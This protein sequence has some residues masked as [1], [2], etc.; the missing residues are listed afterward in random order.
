MNPCRGLRRV[1]GTW[2]FNFSDSY[3]PS[4][5]DGR[6]CGCWGCNHEH[7][8]TDHMLGPQGA[9]VLRSPAVRRCCRLR[10]VAS[11]Y[12]LSPCPLAQRSP[13]LCGQLTASAHLAQVGH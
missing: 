3:L 11:K 8:Q 6:F 4:A 2:E 13:S 7:M 1:P 12:F 5:C 10:I 9:S